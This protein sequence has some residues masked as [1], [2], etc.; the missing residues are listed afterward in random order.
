M[1]NDVQKRIKVLILISRFYM[2]GF[3]KSLINFLLC[4]DAC[5]ELDITVL[6]IQ[7]NQTDDYKNIPER[8]RYVAIDE[9]QYSDPIKKGLN[10]KYL[11]NKQRIRN[12]EYVAVEWKSKLLRIPFPCSTAVKFMSFSEAE[13]ASRVTT[14]FSFADEYDVCISWEEIFC[15]Y[16]LA[17]KI[18]V[19]H[20]IG[21]I[22]PNYRETYFSKTADAPYLKKFDRIVTVSQS[23]KNTLRDVFPRLSD[24]I[25]Y[26]PNRLH[27]GHLQELSDAYDAPM[28]ADDF[29]LLTVARIVDGDKAVF[30]IVSLA[31][32]LVSEGFRFKWYIV[33]DGSDR[34]ELERRIHEKGLDDIIISVGQLDNPCPYMKAADLFVMQSHKEGRPVAVDEAMALGTPALIT[35]YSSAAEQVIN[36]VNGWIAA[37]DESDIYDKMKHIFENK[38]L[39]TEARDNLMNTGKLHYED[40]R[41]MIRMLRD[42]VG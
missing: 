29:N 14:D 38:E 35:A 21:Y 6:S 20:K 33:G 13:R 5:P 40:C 12:I 23:C 26:I 31:Q 2:G 25:V 22:H 3:T 1:T 39:L 36:G 17:E 7:K 37:D 4:A 19:K 32:R 8:F 11:F 24:R 18:P 30:R 42:L 28:N 15:N 34:I 41:E 16:L 27:I 9:L 10:A